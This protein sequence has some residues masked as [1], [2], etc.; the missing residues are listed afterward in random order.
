[1]YN[2]NESYP[3]KKEELYIINKLAINCTAKITQQIKTDKR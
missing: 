3:T 2:F 1:M